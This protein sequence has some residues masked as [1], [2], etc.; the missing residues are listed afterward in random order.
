MR[1]E[2]LS[3]KNF[4]GFEELE[5]DFPAKEQEGGLAVFIGAN[6]S[7]KSSVLDGV[8]CHLKEIYDILERHKKSEKRIRIGSIL[9]KWRNLTEE[10]IYVKADQ[11]NLESIWTVVENRIEL[12]NMMRRDNL[13]SFSNDVFRIIEWK[14]IKEEFPI[15]AFY[16]TNRGITVPSLKA[17][18]LTKLGI[19]ESFQLNNNQEIDFNYFFEW[20]R[21]TEDFENEQRLYKDPNYRHTGLKVLRYVLQTFLKGYINPRVQR[22]P[23]EKL[24]LEKGDDILSVTQLSHGEKLMFALI[25]DI[26][27]R[28]SI[29]QPSLESPL[30]GKGVVMIDE[31]EQHLHP[32]WQRTIIPNLR[33]TFP[34]IQFI[35]TTHSPQVLSN[36]PKENVF[37]LEDFKLVEKTPPTYGKDTNSILY[38]L[39]GVSA[40]P[41]HAKA[42]FKKLYQL[43]DDPTK[44]K[45][46]AK[47]LKEL[48]DK[49]GKNDPD[50]IDAKL[51]FE[52]LI[53]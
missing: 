39:F 1:I 4:R 40:R 41:S 20:F 34:N 32:S 19:E 15:I 44:E 50:L 3:L 45:E 12:S 29:T 53:D 18:D 9:D 47:M 48:E 49:Y 27:R 21:N 36:V 38:D 10:D 26:V 28:I 17:K 11:L 14:K 30:E 24:V 23:I 22:Q 6:G 25:G 13:S 7:G 42:E 37:I 2:K 46:A 51:S 43:I 16:K 52:F 31:I 35:I 33:K 5:I 8:F